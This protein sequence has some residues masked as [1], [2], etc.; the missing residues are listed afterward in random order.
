MHAKVRELKADTFLAGEFEISQL[1][2]LWNKCI[3]SN[4]EK[5]K[6]IKSAKITVSNHV[7]SSQE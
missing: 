2:R 6:S 3:K 5:P 1:G 4:E 7:A